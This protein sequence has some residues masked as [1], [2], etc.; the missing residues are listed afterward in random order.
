M[1]PT[2]VIALRR[3]V[4]SLLMCGALACGSDD[5][6]TT[7][8]ALPA[9]TPTFHADVVPLVYAKCA[10]C[11]LD[12]AIG[13][14]D[15]TKPEVAVAMAPAIAASVASG[16]MPPASRIAARLSASAARSRLQGR[17]RGCRLV[18]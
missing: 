11:H 8:P 12:G 1:N 4:A 5:V 7:V 14:F 6:A 2:L 13:P 15:I 18:L 16:R 17:A 3:T 10:L 9:G